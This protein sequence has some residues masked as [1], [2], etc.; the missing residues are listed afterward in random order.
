VYD[1]R[2]N[3]FGIDSLVSTKVFTTSLISHHHHHVATKELGHLLTHSG[4]T[5]SEV[6]EISG[7]HGGEYEV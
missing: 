1:P 4:L 6:Y 2:L 7:S 5:H 3:H